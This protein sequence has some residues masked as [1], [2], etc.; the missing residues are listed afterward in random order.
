[1]GQIWQEFANHDLSNCVRT[2]QEK[3]QGEI[4]EILAEELW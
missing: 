3:G 1:M 4:G 2:F